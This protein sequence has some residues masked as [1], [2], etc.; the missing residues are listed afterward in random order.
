LQ[1]QLIR[2]NVNVY[3]AE[4]M[5]I[6]IFMKIHE[7]MLLDIAV[8]YNFGHFTFFSKVNMMKGRLGTFNFEDIRN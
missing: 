1:Y 4:P 2:D 7:K 6:N 3:V 8:R 5:V